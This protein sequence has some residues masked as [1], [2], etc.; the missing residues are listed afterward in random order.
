MAIIWTETAFEDLDRLYAF[1]APVNPRAAAK[2]I[3]SLVAAPEALL[4][5]RSI[6]QALPQYLPQDVRRFLVG[7]YEIRYELLDQDILI[8]TIWHQRERR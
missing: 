3:E 5:T 8:L 1:L 2:A 4:P 6:G 7:D